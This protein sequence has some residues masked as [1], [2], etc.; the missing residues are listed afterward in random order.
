[1]TT[2]NTIVLWV[3]VWA[4]FGSIVLGSI[5]KDLEINMW[6]LHSVWWL[7]V[8]IDLLWPVITVLYLRS[9]RP[10]KKQ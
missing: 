5:D 4:M 3:I 9:K 8:L 10:E 7:N 2:F 6:K 1:M